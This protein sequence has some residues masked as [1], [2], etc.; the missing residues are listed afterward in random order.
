MLQEAQEHLGAS[1]RSFTYELVDAQSIPY[2]N[3]YF[4]AV[5]ANHM[6]YHVR[7]R[8]RALSEIRRVL[9]PGGRFFAA[10]NGLCHLRELDDLIRRWDPTAALWGGRP[11]ERFSLE[12]GDVELASWFTGIELRRYEDGL[13]VTEA[14]P[15]VA[16]ILSS[17]VGSGIKEEA[18]QRLADLIEGELA[19]H[20]A[21]QI[22][23]DA[24]L[25]L[26]RRAEDG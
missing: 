24:G 2:P 13:V 16:Y 21:I 26:A 20:G 19:R 18:R 9:R 6:L 8:A 15:L 4:D 22:T 14:E 11:E 12:T 1:S 5:I 17:G 23:K 7:D 10:T 25:F 3:D